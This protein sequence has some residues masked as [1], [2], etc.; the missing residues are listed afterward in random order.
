MSLDDASR[1]LI[2][3]AVIQW[4]IT[5]VSVYLARREKQ[6]ALTF[7]VAM[8]IILSMATTLGAI[9]G[10]VTLNDMP[11]PPGFF[12]SSLIAMFLAIALVQPIWAVGVWL[13]RFK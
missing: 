4:P 8:F 5:L 6:S 2:A 11:V 9:L 7:T 13:G 3:A 10:W 12:A 1:L